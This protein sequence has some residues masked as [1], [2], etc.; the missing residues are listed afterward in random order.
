MFGVFLVVMM[1]VV[2]WQGGTAVS[3]TG[4]STAYL[5]LIYD[6]YDSSLSPIFG[7]QTYGDIQPDSV[8]YDSLIGTNAKWMRNRASWRSIE[9][10]NVTPDAYNWSSA[11]GAYAVAH[12][13]NGG[14]NV[15]GTIEFAPDWAAPAENGP[16]YPDALDD[17]AEFMSAIV[18]RF[19]GDGFEDAPGSPIVTYWEIY[20]EPDNNSDVN[21]PYFA[22][23]MHWG[24]HGA[25][26]ANMLA[27]IYPAI[28]AANPQAQV[29]IGGLA[30]D[31][32][33]AEGGPFVESFLSDVLAAGGGNYFD[34]MNFH[35][36]PAFYSRWTNNLG[37]GLL[38][39]AEAV[40][41]VLADYGLEKPVIVTEAGWMSNERP[42]AFIPGSPEIQARY[43]VQLFTESMAADLDVMIWWLLFD[44][45]F[46][47]PFMN[48][49]V[50]EGPLV[51]PKLSYTVYQNM[52]AEL[53]TTHFVRS[54]SAVEMGHSFM[55][56]HLFED[57]V[58]RRYLYVAWLNRVD[59]MET[60]PLQIV[61]TT[62][63]VTDSLT[64]DMFVV[65][66]G[67]DGSV[68]GL[69]TVT[70]GANPLYVEVAR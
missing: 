52:V 2:V 15:I 67:A 49:L 46:P 38:G 59:T 65:Q 21:S 60:A 69:V 23:P 33:E 9:P 35:S 40:R 1:G 31:W 32:F 68:D 16:L 50:T 64:G 37:P 53:G 11:D 61:A 47:Y 66:D 30:L 4:I 41:S 56:A 20:N 22:E 24:D 58:H 6:K 54:L 44:P 55:E 43:V 10:V 36:Y 39:K 42:G 28:K 3:A 25:E 17:F 45:A 8:Y 27:T 34:V 51:E 70:V 26:Y 63:K 19:D 29:V 18:E 57:N 12:P 62:A 5:P 7:V 48:G 14:L 13:E